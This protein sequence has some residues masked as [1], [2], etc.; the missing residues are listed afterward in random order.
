MKWK[1]KSGYFDPF[2]RAKSA[3]SRYKN[4][5]GYICAVEKNFFLKEESVLVG[6]YTCTSTT[7]IPVRIKN[8]PRQTQ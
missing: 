1:E 7:S 5:K 8:Y 4:S 6:N 3:A 2:K